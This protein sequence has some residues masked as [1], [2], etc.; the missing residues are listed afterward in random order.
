MPKFTEMK[1]TSGRY[2]H[3][4]RETRQWIPGSAVDRHFPYRF[5]GERNMLGSDF[6]EV[7]LWCEQRFKR[8]KLWQAEM[9]RVMFREELD[10]FEFKMRWC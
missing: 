5:L 1:T 2:S 4:D 7:V 9:P 8:R 3:W 10:G 6:A